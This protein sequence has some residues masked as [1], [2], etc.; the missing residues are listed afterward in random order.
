MQTDVPRQAVPQC[1]VADAASHRRVGRPGAVVPAR[2]YGC[3][4]HPAGSG[5]HRQVSPGVD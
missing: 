4:A 2:L 5:P 3:P 1:S